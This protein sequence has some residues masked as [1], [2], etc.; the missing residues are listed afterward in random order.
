MKALFILMA[1]FCVVGCDNS[2][3]AR[4]TLERSQ[5]R[6]EIL[7]KRCDGQ[8]TYGVK[9]HRNIFGANDVIHYTNFRC[10]PNGIQVIK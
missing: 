8:I 2:E 7:Q 6:L 9:V 4:A 5:R 10:I 1:L 3:H